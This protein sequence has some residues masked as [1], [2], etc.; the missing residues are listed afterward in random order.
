MNDM[1]KLKAKDRHLFIFISSTE[2]GEMV[3]FSIYYKLVYYVP[4]RKVFIVV[5]MLLI[6]SLFMLLF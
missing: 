6:I 3:T 2:I 5:I 1:S 4:T